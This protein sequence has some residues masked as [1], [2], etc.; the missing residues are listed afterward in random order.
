MHRMQDA[1]GDQLI[2]SQTETETETQRLAKQHGV[3]GPT[4]YFF[5]THTAQST[6][7]RTQIEVKERVLT[8]F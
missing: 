4:Y 2:V 8:D 3:C 5:N 7:T 1:E 6:H